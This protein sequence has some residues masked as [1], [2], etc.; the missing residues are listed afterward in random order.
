MV[1]ENYIVRFIRKD[2]LPIEDYIYYELEDA[3]KHFKL[4]EKD[5]SGLYNKIILL[6]CYG[7]RTMVVR[8][9]EFTSK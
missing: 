8:E 6:F 3:E 5:D 9:I 1:D 4:F 7:D 2:K